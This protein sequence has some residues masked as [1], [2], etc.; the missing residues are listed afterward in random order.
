MSDSFYIPA[1]LFAYSISV[2]KYMQ[3]CSRPTLFSSDALISTSMERQKSLRDEYFNEMCFAASEYKVHKDLPPND[4]K[5]LHTVMQSI[6]SKCHT[7]KKVYFPS[8]LW[9]SNLQLIPYTLINIFGKNNNRKHWM[10][11]EVKCEDGETL[12]LD[13]YNE[14]PS[15]SHSK[16][17]ILILHHG[18]N[19]RSIDLPGQQY[20][21]YAA[22]KGWLIVCYHRR[23][24]NAKLTKHNFNMFGNS[25]ETSYVVQTYI[26]SKRPQGKCLFLGFSAGSGIV[27]RYM[28]DQGARIKRLAMRVKQEEGRELDVYGK[29]LD[30]V[31]KNVRGFVYSAVGICPGYNIERCLA[32]FAE[33]FQTLI[34][35]T[36]NQWYL[37][38]NRA[39]LEPR[40]DLGY[41]ECMAATSLQSWLDETYKFGGFESKKAYYDNCNPMRTVEHTITP[42]L[43]LN[44]EDDPICSIRNLWEALYIFDRPNG[45]MVATV[46]AGSH[47]PFYQA[48]L[49]SVFDWGAKTFAEELALDW[50]DAVLEEFGEKEG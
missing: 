6:V 34:L 36:T 44:A 43:Y 8:F 28:G 41:D 14:V 47:C 31:A 10:K 33:P 5:T 24:H 15:V 19:C 35:K 32:L 9:P 16:D 42:C 21:K 27:A 1:I 11:E 37:G 26:Q 12:A 7:F 29:D 30:Y 25:D 50:F 23:G 49:W 22:S 13:W 48:G 45:A 38:K 40:K 2:V 20:I 46:K 3:L 4:A 18:V 39:L 17:V